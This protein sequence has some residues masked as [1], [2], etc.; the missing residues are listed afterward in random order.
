[1]TVEITVRGHPREILNCVNLHALKEELFFSPEWL[2][3]T[4][5]YTFKKYCI[6]LRNKNTALS[7]VYLFW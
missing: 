7:I 5:K 1:M 2:K 4:Q 3:I 6:I